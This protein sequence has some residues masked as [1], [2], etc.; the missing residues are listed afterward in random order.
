MVFSATL[1][2]SVRPGGSVRAPLLTGVVKMRPAAGT[3]INFSC[4]MNFG[5]LYQS[6]PATEA[7]ITILIGELA[8][9]KK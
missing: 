2:F 5:V 8:N 3:L 6:T 7:P 1:E 9:A 4:K